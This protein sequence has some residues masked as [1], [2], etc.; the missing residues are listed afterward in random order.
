MM[1]SLDRY[2]QNQQR[3]ECELLCNDNYDVSG[4]FIVS[5]L[6][7]E[8]G[9]TTFPFFGTILFPAAIRNFLCI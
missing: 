1:S 9:L 5:R 3:Q 8:G 7:E 6:A 2:L 4:K